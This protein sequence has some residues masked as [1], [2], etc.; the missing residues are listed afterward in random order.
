MINKK[1][2]YK[3]K[4]SIL[5]IEIKKIIWKKLCKN[6]NNRPTIYIYF[7]RSS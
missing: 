6:N 5:K 2:I 1:I 4:I 7:N 3:K